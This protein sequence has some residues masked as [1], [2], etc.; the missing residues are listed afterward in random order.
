MVEPARVE[1][2]S[3][4]DPPPHSTGLVTVFSL[5]ID[6]PVTGYHWRPP[7]ISQH[8]PECDQFMP[9]PLYCEY[10]GPEDLDR[11]LVAA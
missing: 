3:E 7:T 2:A 6:R 1:L 10:Y 8:E 5:T 9:S 4:K 11:K